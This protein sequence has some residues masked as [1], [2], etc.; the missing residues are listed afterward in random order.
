MFNDKLFNKNDDD[1]VNTSL[2][3]GKRGNIVRKIKKL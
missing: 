2:L 3:T 1:N